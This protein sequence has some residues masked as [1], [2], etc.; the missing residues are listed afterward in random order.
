M[1]RGDYLGEFEQL[2]LAAL[3][4]LRENAYAIHEQ[5]E[6]LAAGFRVVSLGACY[7]TLDRLEQKGYVRSWFGGATEE[8]GGRS[9]RFFE[10]TGSGE[11][12]VKNALR[13]ADNMVTGLREI[14]G[15]A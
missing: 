1:A 3:M 6:K 2:I 5:V 9:K 15:L 4:I 13:V 8:R 12:A 11:K 14:G 7:T 10:I